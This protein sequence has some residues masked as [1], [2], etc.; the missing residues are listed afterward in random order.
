MKTNTSLLTALLFTAVQALPAADPAGPAPSAAASQNR[1]AFLYEPTPGLNMPGVENKE[2][3]AAD[4]IPFFHNGRFHVLHL[5]LKP[6]QV[7]W[8]WAQIVTQDFVNYEHTGVAIP[9]G[10]PVDMDRD[11]FTGSVIEKDG[12][13]Y[14]FYTGHNDSFKKE[15]QPDQRMFRATSTDG[16]NWTKDKDFVLTPEG[17]SRYRWP[18]AFRDGFVFWNPEKKEYGMLV[19]ASLVNA[20]KGGLAYASSADLKTW[21]MGEPFPA[22]G[23]FAGYECPDLF[24]WED[25]WYLI[26][27]TYWNNPGWT[28]RYMTAPKLEGPWT[29]PTDPFFDGGTLYAAKSASDGQRRFLCGT[30]PRR[31][32]GDDGIATDENDN[33]WGGRLLVYEMH[34]RPD[35]TLGVRIPPEVEQS[36]GEAAPLTMPNLPASEWTRKDQGLISASGPARATLGTLPD[37]AFVSV[38][39]TVPP[40]GRAGFWFGGAEE[41]K[42]GHLVA[43]D[44][45][46]VYVDAGT[47]RLCWD[48]SES[49]LGANPEKERNYRPLKVKPGDRVRLKV[50]IDGNA[51]VASANDDVCLSTRM[52]DRGNKSF[53]VWADTVGAGFSDL[54]IRKDGPAKP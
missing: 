35:G 23:H 45:F 26:F 29:S 3:L 34:R 30:L 5:Q 54:T 36:F 22:S 6:G 37:R 13:L 50:A 33:G 38:E 39:L 24:F 12:M 7:G 32:P 27:S 2:G 1:T 14:A 18:G 40:T 52:Y 20:G 42:V 51:A 10:Q 17:D 11:I 41:R 43:E 48:R 53:G 21:K 4:V 31:N 28:T 15:N 16:V 49:R 47:G 25:R 46:R 44:A 19:T 8:D 9:G